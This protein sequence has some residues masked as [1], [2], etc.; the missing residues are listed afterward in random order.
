VLV[1]DDTDI[2]RELIC[3]NLELEGFEV[4]TAFDG[5]DALDKVHD[6]DPDVVT[7]DVV[8]PRLDG[9]QAAERLRADA[10]TATL[11][12]VMVSAAAQE[13]DLRRGREIGV[14]AYL[15]KPFDP[16]ELVQIIRAL[17]AGR[18]VPDL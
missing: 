17:I 5:Q 4:H 16:D 12:I 3:V 13:A 6:V 8:M 15:T 9:F 18:S 14:N 7:L 2:I 1:V 10:R 11:P